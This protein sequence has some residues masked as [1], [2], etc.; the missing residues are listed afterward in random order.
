M[1]VVKI[2]ES[3]SRGLDGLGREVGFHVRPSG[4]CGRGCR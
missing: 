1:K 2:G 4:D 3:W